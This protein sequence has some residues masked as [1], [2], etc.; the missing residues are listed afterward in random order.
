MDG[1]KV[2]HRRAV[3]TRVIKD[4]EFLVIEVLA[5]SRDAQISNGFAWHR[6]QKS[7]LT[8]FIAISLMILSLFSH[9]IYRKKG[10]VSIGD[11]GGLPTGAGENP[12]TKH[13]GRSQHGFSIQK[14]DRASQAK[15]AS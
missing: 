10:I 8:S 4:S 2:S 12:A 9:R 7:L 1:N 15:G 5:P 3:T 11:T 14:R 6:M 13:G